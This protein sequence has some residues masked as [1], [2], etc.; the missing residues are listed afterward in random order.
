[1]EESANTQLQQQQMSLNS[2]SCVQILNSQFKSTQQLTD[3]C[4]HDMFGLMNS[5]QQ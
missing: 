3:I 2:Q 4:D 5:A 1:M